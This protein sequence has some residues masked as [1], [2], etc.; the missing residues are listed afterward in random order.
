MLTGTPSTTPKGWAEIFCQKR[1][2]PKKKRSWIYL[3]LL[4]GGLEDRPI[5]LGA[6]PYPDGVDYVVL[7]DPDGNLFCVVQE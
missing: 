5:G 1:A 4:C 6:W 2:H 3:V 7:E